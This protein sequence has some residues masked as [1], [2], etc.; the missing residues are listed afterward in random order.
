MK[1]KTAM[2]RPRFRIRA[3]LVAFLCLVVLAA[4]AFLVVVGI[5]ERTSRHENEWAKQ[6]Q[7]IVQEIPSVKPS[8]GD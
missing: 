5:D 7:G 6:R 8:D 2:S 1:R 4:I 3:I